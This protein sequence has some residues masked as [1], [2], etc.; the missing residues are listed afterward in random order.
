MTLS[1]RYY[2][3]VGEAFHQMMEGRN[4]E[5]PWVTVG[6]VASAAHVSPMTAKK[7]LDHAFY[8]GEIRR[9]STLSGRCLYSSN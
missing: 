4:N 3:I 2:Q 6:E 5:V 8:A 7:Y 1:E 9:I